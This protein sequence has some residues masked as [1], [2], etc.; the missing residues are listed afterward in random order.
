[1]LLL[2]ACSAGQPPIE[3]DVIAEEEPIEIAE[4]IDEPTEP[5]EPE[6]PEE[7]AE[8]FPQFALTILHTNDLHGRLENMAQYY[9]IIQRVRG[10]EANVLLLDGGDLYRRGPYE[11]LNGAVET[12]VLN[13]MG[14]TAMVFGN[15]DFPIND[16]ELYDVSEHTILQLAE[17]AVLC[18]NVTIDGEYIEGTQPY[19]IINFEGINVAII[20]ITSMK[21]RDRGYDITERALFSDPVQTLSELA[22]E[23]K[24]LSDIQIVLS[25]A[26]IDV[27]MRMSGVSAIVSADTHVKTTVPRLILNDGEFIPV[28]QA[29]GEHDNYL[30]RLDLLF[31]QRD[32]GWTLA[33]FNGFLYSLEDIIPSAEILSIL[34]KYDIPVTD[35]DEADDSRFIYEDAA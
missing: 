26:G 25:H 22:E 11:H 28:V 20:G 3:E 9:T 19:I 29:G 24:P 1:M 16:E 13:A 12:E 21:P 35:N 4:E 31:E 27:D 6:E 30:G 14:Y 32:G 34:E 8:E 15:G 5:Q 2:S 33:S 7:E 23:T 18:G 10:E 17:F